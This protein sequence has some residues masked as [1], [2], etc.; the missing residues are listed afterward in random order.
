[1]FNF[2]LNLLNIGC[3][4]L[5]EQQADKIRILNFIALS[6]AVIAF[7]YSSFYFFATN[8]SSLVLTNNLFAMSYILPVILNHFRHHLVGKNTLFSVVI[9]HMTVLTTELLTLQTGFHLYLLLVFPAVFL[10]FDENEFKYAVTFSM[11]SG[12]ALVYCEFINN[13]QPVVTL[14]NATNRFLFHTTLAVVVSEL[15]LVNYLFTTFFYKRE[16]A[17]EILA[18][19]DPL[20]ALFNRRYFSHVLDGQVKHAAR[21]SRP[22]SLVLID[23]DYFKQVNDD[24]GHAVGDRLL[25]ETATILRENCRINDIVSR[26]GGEEFTLILPETGLE[27]A[28]KTCEKLRQSFEYHKFRIDELNSIQITISLGIC[29]W[30]N[31]QDSA[32]VMLQK[33]DKALYKAKDDG[34][35]RISV[36]TGTTILSN[37]WSLSGTNT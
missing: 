35:N 2:I 15:I 25:V 30:Q 1:M 22:F 10:L 8:S 13:Q 23:L 36:N 24:Y 3:E 4:K 33:V 5:N 9:I 20:T 31:S 26:I 6:S 11:L 34:R 32:E 12:G 28:F 7:A 18:N 37:H 19:T 29:E 14:T 27:N 17:A 16:K 21:Y